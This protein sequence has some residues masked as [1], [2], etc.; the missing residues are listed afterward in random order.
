MLMFSYKNVKGIC[1]CCSTTC[2]MPSKQP[3]IQIF[4]WCFLMNFSFH[5][6]FTQKI[7]N[8][9]PNLVKYNRDNLLIGL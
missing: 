4:I 3:N 1:L 5:V 8:T 6:L 9:C 2:L 7:F